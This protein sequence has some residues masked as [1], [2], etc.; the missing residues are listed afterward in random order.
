MQALSREIDGIQH[1]QAAYLSDL[2]SKVKRDQV[3]FK[4]WSKSG[5][6][7]LRI[8]FTIFDDEDALLAFNEVFLLYLNDLTDLNDV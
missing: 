6:Q 7:V 4:F 2:K 1:Y 3:K 8:P 5:N